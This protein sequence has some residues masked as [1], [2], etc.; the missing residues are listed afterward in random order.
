MLLFQ[1]CKRSFFPPWFKKHFAFPIANTVME[2][3]KEWHSDLTASRF[4]VWA[5]GWLEAFLWKV[6]MFSV[7]VLPVLGS[8]FH[9]QSKYMWIKLTGSILL[10]VTVSLAV[11]WQPVQWPQVFPTVNWIGSSFPATHMSSKVIGF[12]DDFFKIFTDKYCS[13]EG[14][15]Q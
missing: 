7:W 3:Y 5:L 2:N 15:V 10:S 9:P 14:I 12:L 4:W 11:D 1:L 13:P 6:C 8:G